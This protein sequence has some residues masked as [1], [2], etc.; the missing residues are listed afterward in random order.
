M[1]TVS[2]LLTNLFLQCVL[3]LWHPVRRLNLEPTVCMDGKEG[4]SIPHLMRCLDSHLEQYMA[5]ISTYALHRCLEPDIKI[6]QR[7]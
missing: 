5:T 4:R 1:N 6:P 7:K 2:L 3:S